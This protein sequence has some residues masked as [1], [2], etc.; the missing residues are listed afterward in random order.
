MDNYTLLTKYRPSSLNEIKGQDRIVKLLKSISSIQSSPHFLFVGRSGVGKTATA[1]AFANHLDVDVVEMNSSDER[2]IDTVR[3]KI[4][5][6][7][8]SASP[9]ILLLDEAD[10]MTKDAQFA[11]RRLSEIVIQKNMPSRIIMTA[12]YEHK[13]ITAI[14]SR[15]AVLRFSVLKDDA[16]AEIVRDV[17]KN[18]KVRND[19]RI[20]QLI[21]KVAKGDARSALNYVEMLKKMDYEAFVSYIA[22]E[23]TR[24]SLA[25]E[26][27]NA[28]VDGNWQ[29]VYFTLKSL[30]YTHQADGRKVAEVLFDE[31]EE[32]EISSYLKLLIYKSLAYAEQGI[33]EECNP[34]IQL[35]AF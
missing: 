16:I 14:K 13:I 35:S 12:N 17:M 29:K 7:L 19:E 30:F 23:A 24:V 28:C 22:E 4:K 5:T 27:L 15:F 8:F 11:L 34:L 26:V 9:K 6:I 18:E 1:Y 3:E 25:K 21:A 10:Q 20:V 33:N 2:G 32:L 31:I